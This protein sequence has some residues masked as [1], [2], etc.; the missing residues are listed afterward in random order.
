MDNDKS[1]G[2]SP[3]DQKST[4]GETVKPSSITQHEGESQPEAV[5]SP[6][7]VS[8]SEPKKPPIKEKPPKPAKYRVVDELLMRC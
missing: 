7:K 5:A 1:A 8:V 3:E 4:E 6:S 2:N